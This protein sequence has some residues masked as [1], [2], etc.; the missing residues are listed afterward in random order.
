MSDTFAPPAT[1]EL[2]AVALHLTPL[3]PVVKALPGLRGSEGELGELLQRPGATR[4]FAQFVST[5]HENGHFV[6]YREPGA[7]RLAMDFM[8]AMVR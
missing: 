1:A 7:A 4:A 3:D 5:R 2:L 8:R 6:L